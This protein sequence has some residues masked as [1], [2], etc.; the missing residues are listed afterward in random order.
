MCSVVMRVG[1]DQK[2]GEKED[3]LGEKKAL[4]KTATNLGAGWTGFHRDAFVAKINSAL[5]RPSTAPTWGG[6][7]NEMA[8]DVGGGIAG[9][10]PYVVGNTRSSNSPPQLAAKPERGWMY[11]SAVLGR[12]CERSGT[13]GSSLVFSSYL[14]GSGDDMGIGYPDWIPRQYLRGGFLFFRRFQRRS[15]VYDTSNLR[16]T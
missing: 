14:G 11:H 10:H 7:A 2:K 1:G 12:V 4:P 16:P 15:A 9:R 5:T 3:F 8:N 6:S 13:N